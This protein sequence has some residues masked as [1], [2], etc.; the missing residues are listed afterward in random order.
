M[1]NICTQDNVS[2]DN[3]HSKELKTKTFVL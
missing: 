1:H 3:Q 2:T